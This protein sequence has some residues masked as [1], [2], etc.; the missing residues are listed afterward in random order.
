MRENAPGRRA[1]VTLAARDLVGSASEAVAAVWH[2]AC[3]S[4]RGSDKLEQAKPAAAMRVICAWCQKEGRRG[5]LRVRE[6]LD[7]TTDTH[8]I[9]D[10][11]QQEVLEGFPAT[12]F[13]S[14]RW[15]F[16]VPNGDT[17]GYEHLRKI[18]KDVPGA[19]VI[20]DRRRGD[21]RGS[22]EAR[23]PD[24]RRADRRVRRPEVSGLGYRLV[25]FTIRG[26][27]GSGTPSD[28]SAGC[29][30]DEGQAGPIDE[31]Y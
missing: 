22:D 11:H 12:S 6:P 19:T 29:F 17:A 20:V 13:P 31:R 16:I 30:A 10:R 4:H 8:G 21:R 27:A 18:L 3:S 23:A 9:C 28:P 5:L 26:P 2:T 24:R 14:T 15:L 7:D 1:L 25:R